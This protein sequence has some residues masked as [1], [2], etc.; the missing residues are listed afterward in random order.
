MNE[1][2][3]TMDIT[4]ETA[5]MALEQF[6]KF[7]GRTFRE[8]QYEAIEFAMKSNKPVVAIEAPTGSGKSLIGA[9]LSLLSGDAIYLVHSKPLQSQVQDDFPEFEILKGRSN[10]ICNYDM[11]K[12]CDECPFVTPKE[13]CEQYGFC[14]YRVQKE[15]TLRHPLRVLN[16]A[17]F[18]NECNHVGKFSGKPLIICDEADTLEGELLKFIS[19]NISERQLFEHKIGLPKYKT[20]GAK[21]GLSSWMDWAR[22][23]VQKIQPKIEALREMSERDNTGETKK[24][25]DQ[26]NNLVTNLDIFQRFVDDTWIC[27]EIDER[28]NKRWIWTPTWLTTELTETYLLRHGKKFILMSATFPPLHVLCKTL[29]IDGNSLDYMEIP[30]TFPPE[31]RPIY[32]NPVGNMG[33]KT[34]EAEFHKVQ[35]EIIRILAE[36]PNDKGL[37]HTSSYKLARMIEGIDPDRMISHNTENRLDTLEMFKNSTRPLVMVSPS[38]ERGISLNDELCRFVIVAKC[39]YLN[40]GD[41]QTSTRVYSSRIGNYWYKAMTAQT[42]EQQVGR[43]IRSKNDYCH[44]YLLDTHIAKLLCENPKLFSE[45]FME[46]IA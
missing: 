43:G 8:Y 36:H 39:P 13:G 25:Y 23:S 29:G 46:C 17:Y 38:M 37:I 20:T 26:A 34:M 14:N 6:S 40:L 12:R 32:L 5:N 30:C 9:I 41:K 22:E 24:Q 19:L 16:Y 10:Y 27:Q 7:K 31:N 44:V 21:E 3:S 45:Y 18:L 4:P 2:I 42:L 28:R 35:D 1:E 11:F 15:A 33:A